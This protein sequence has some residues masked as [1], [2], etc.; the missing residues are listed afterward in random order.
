ME[1][2]LYSDLFEE[3]NKSLSE[4][5]D[6]VQ[7]LD[8]EV[9]NLLSEFG[10]FNIDPHAFDLT[11]NV[12]MESD[13]V[14]DYF[15]N[16]MGSMYKNQD[17]VKQS[18][19]QQDIEIKKLTQQNKQLNEKL[20]AASVLNS[21]FV[22]E[23]SKTHKNSNDDK[24]LIKDLVDFNRRTNAIVTINVD[25]DDVLKPKLIHD[26]N[27]VLTHKKE[28]EELENYLK[29]IK[30]KLETNI[31][32]PNSDLEL[33]TSIIALNPEEEDMVSLLTQK[34][35]VNLQL[36]HELEVRNKTIRELVQKFSE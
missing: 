21:K 34:E 28:Q 15:S 12:Q 4:D 9:D 17:D 35:K 1:D 29:S 36:Q 33:D 14:I 10:K 7:L 19:Q 5:K 16:R 2:N 6:K 11:D 27:K 13:D 20:N 32:E 22:A 23:Y 26:S 31:F 8:D 18:L 25:E 24:D 3:L 30:N